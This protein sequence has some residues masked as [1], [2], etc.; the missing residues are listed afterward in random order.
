MSASSSAAAHS[1]TASTSF[2]TKRLYTCLTACPH[3]N[4][5]KCAHLHARLW[6]H[7]PTFATHALA[8]A[9]VLALANRYRVSFPPGYDQTAEVVEMFAFETLAQ[10][11]WPSCQSSMSDYHASLVGLAIMPV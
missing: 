9:L 10:A 6:R 7:S 8:L 5:F 11:C 4:I 3:T 1:P 2:R